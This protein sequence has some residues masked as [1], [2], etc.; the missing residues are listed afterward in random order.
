MTLLQVDASGLDAAETE[1]SVS[2]GQL[3]VHSAVI[4]TDDDKIMT[5]VYANCYK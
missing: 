2:V 3:G 1:W 4:F 5:F